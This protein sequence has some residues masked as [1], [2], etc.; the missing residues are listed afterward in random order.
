MKLTLMRKLLVGFSIMIMILI[1]TGVYVLATLRDL[2]QM[3]ERIVKKNFA[4]IEAAGQMRENLNAQD[5]YEKRPD[6]LRDPEA[7]ALFN[8]RGKDFRRKLDQIPFL[9]EKD[10]PIRQQIRE[11]HDE[12]VQ[13][14]NEKAARLDPKTEPS[15]KVISREQM[16]TRFDEIVR[17]LAALETQARNDQ[18][19]QI[20]RGGELSQRAFN[21]TAVLVVMGILFSVGFSV[22][23]NSNIAFSFRQLQQA[24]QFIEQGMFDHALSIKA[25]EDV[26][27]LTESFRSMSKRLK[28]LG[29]INLDAN[30]LTR[31]PGNLAIE[32][33]L[34]MR[35]HSEAPFAFCLV[36]LDN[37][38][39]FG[40][41]YGYARG[42]EVLKE[43]GEILVETVKTLG[44]GGDF[45]GHIGGD[46]FVIITE[47]SRI[48]KLC[49]NVIN[50]FDETIPKYYD[51]EDRTRGFIISHDRKDVE[52]KFPIMT[53][54]IAVVTNQKR[55]ITSPMQVAEIVAQLKQYAKTFPRSVYVVDQRRMV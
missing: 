28:E 16:K 25:P 47:P 13:F 31:L 24:T 4:M 12:Y 3:S 52:Q 35:L 11:W 27:E 32:K 22:F 53:V 21:V 20:I 41:R 9:L 46:D 34:L 37:F 55:A 48:S 50:D 40:D 33:V 10:E 45:I 7:R 49:E 2:Q 15:A 26:R 6:L 51:E 19:M 43:V 30:P 36:D 23:I 44:M 1:M 14:I 29:E 5:F 18:G 42:S 17:L 39:A 8:A 38:K 54:S